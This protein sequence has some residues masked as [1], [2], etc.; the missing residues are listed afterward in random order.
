MSGAIK[1]APSSSYARRRLLRKFKSD[2]MVAL[3]VLATVLGLVPLFLVLGYLLSKG[4]SSVNWNFFTRMPA[5]VG[6]PGGGMANAIIGTLEI[7]RRRHRHGVPVGIGAGIYAAQNPA[8]WLAKAVRFA[9]DINDGGS[10]R[11]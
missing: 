2:F 6:Q 10:H 7:G 9:A 8:L 3:T 1:T 11:S 4:A 5:P